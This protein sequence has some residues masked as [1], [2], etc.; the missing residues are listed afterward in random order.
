MLLDRLPLL[1]SCMRGLVQL[2]LD[3]PALLPHA[4]TIQILESCSRRACTLANLTWKKSEMENQPFQQRSLPGVLDVQHVDLVELILQLSQFPTPPSSAGDFSSS[5]PMLAYSAL[6]WR[7]CVLLVILSAFNPQTIGRVVWERVPTVRCML[8]MCISEI[9]QTHPSISDTAAPTPTQTQ[10]PTT[11]TASATVPSTLS[12]TSLFPPFPDL[13]TKSLLLH[14]QRE[15]ND[16]VLYI[17]NLLPEN[18]PT[19]TNTEQNH[20]DTSQNP[21]GAAAVTSDTEQRQTAAAST[22]VRPSSIAGPRTRETSLY[23]RHHYLMLLDPSEVLRRPPEPVL[24]TLYRLSTDFHLGWMMRRS[25]QP[26]F[27]AN[28]LMRQTPEQYVSWLHRLITLDTDT[29]HSLPHVPNAHM[30]MHAVERWSRRE[31]E[32][33]EMIACEGTSA[34]HSPQCA[35]ISSSE[36]SSS[37]PLLDLLP[38]MLTSLRRLLPQMAMMYATTGSSQQHAGDVEAS[39]RSQSVG[40]YPQPTTIIASLKSPNLQSAPTTPAIESTKPQPIATPSSIFSGAVFNHSPFIDVLS[41]FMQGLGSR[42]AAQRQSAARALHFW[43]CPHSLPLTFS[44]PTTIPTMCAG[45]GGGVHRWQPMDLT[46]DTLPSLPSVTCWLRFF[47]AWFLHRHPLDSCEHKIES[48]GSD[49]ASM[50]SSSPPVSAAFV[51]SSRQVIATV[52]SALLSALEN[53]SNDDA[54]CGYLI[55]LHSLSTR[56][57]HSPPPHFPPSRLFR[58]QLALHV[59]DV[60]LSREMLADELLS[61][62]G[63]ASTSRRPR[64]IT[65]NKQSEEEENENER[66]AGIDSSKDHSLSA[67]GTMTGNNVKRRKLSTMDMT[68]LSS[69][70]TFDLEGADSGME[71]SNDGIDPSPP[72]LS[73]SSSIQHDSHPDSDSHLLQSAFSG[74]FVVLSIL[75]SAF[76]VVEYMQ[77]DVNLVRRLVAHS[78]TQ[79]QTN[80]NGNL[81]SED[82]ELGEERDWMEDNGHADGQMED[83]KMSIEESPMHRPTA[84]NNASLSPLSLPMSPPLSAARDAATPTLSPGASGFLQRSPSSDSSISS[85]EFVS[86]HRSWPTCP[87]PILVYVPLP[88]VHGIMQFLAYPYVGTRQQEKEEKEQAEQPG[89]TTH[90]NATANQ[91]RHAAFYAYQH[92]LTMLLPSPT[93]PSTF[94]AVSIPSASSSLPLPS[95]PLSSDSVSSWLID[96]SGIRWPLPSD[97]EAYRILTHSATP[98][99]IQLTIERCAPTQL[100]MA[101]CEYGMKASVAARCLSRLD[102]WGEYQMRLVVGRAGNVSALSPAMRDLLKHIDKLIRCVQ[103]HQANIQRIMNEMESGK[104]EQ[105][106]MLM[107]HERPTHSGDIGS[108]L[109]VYLHSLQSL[110]QC[111]INCDEKQARGENSQNTTQRHDAD[112]RLVDSAISPHAI[113]QAS[114]SSLFSSIQHLIFSASDSIPYSAFLSLRGLSA[115]NP[116][117]FLQCVSQAIGMSECESESESERERVGE[118]DGGNVGED[119]NKE[120]ESGSGSESDGEVGAERQQQNGNDI[121]MASRNDVTLPSLSASASA[122][123]SPVPLHL[124][125]ILP[126]LHDACTR[127]LIN[128][129]MDID[130][131]IDADSMKGATEGCMQTQEGDTADEYEF[132]QDYADDYSVCECDGY[133]ERNASIAEPLSHLSPCDVHASAIVQ[134]HSSGSSLLPSLLSRLDRMFAGSPPRGCGASWEQN[135]RIIAELR[136][137]YMHTHTHTYAMNR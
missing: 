4:L 87:A 96:S 7:C 70:P 22:S 129:G 136:R 52:R 119:E 57:S 79:T 59:C 77:N 38:S 93:P 69:M 28:M 103:M 122:S 124:S 42:S 89:C 58:V 50:P 16:A 55:F 94:H 11:G 88:L 128:H 62:N 20:N 86:L 91:Q 82:D 48:S 41:V 127:I 101:L 116:A 46:T 112:G 33:E 92:L 12:L 98:A 61:V 74:Y 133:D 25:K 17:E 5:L 10:S 102:A 54:V 114:D 2:S 31:D 36:S 113:I 34:L 66:A 29:I 81:M 73:R 24:H 13:I 53:E 104:D 135:R 99:L 23:L 97:A 44:S 121:E 43:I 130:L 83:D 56:Y 26:H 35:M 107:Q 85:V 63:R 67:D 3:Q 123:S 45:D 27:L 15:E 118:N 111:E 80:G 32:R 134:S 90:D 65:S 109:L 72:T 49:A 14:R 68:S 117:A 126:F 19:N 18:R 95:F 30:T 9:W 78:Q 75:H 125:R 131:D 47:Y 60:I 6:F 8:E 76:R 105:Q 100:L 51:Q 71:L 37:D 115:S 110:Q 39:V 21:A 132:Q 120:G 1:E 40:N 106:Q 84:P 137:T 64:I 108:T